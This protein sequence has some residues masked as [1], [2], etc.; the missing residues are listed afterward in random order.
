MLAALIIVFREVFEAGLIIGIVLAVTRQVQHRNRWIVGGVLAGVAGACLVAAFAGA[1]SQLFEGMGQELFNAAILGVAVV[2][3]T[4]HNVW[5]AKHGKE[6]AGEL[7]AVG[8]AVAQGSKSLLALAVVVGVAVLREG[9][10]VA[11]FLYG[12]AASDGGSAMSL[13]LGGLLGL[14]LGGA[15]CLFTYLGLLRIPPRALFNTTTALITL[16]AAGM[17][18]QAVA[19]LERANWL[20]ALD[21]VVWDT[22]WLLSENSILGRTLHTLIGYTDQP[23]QMQLVIY[24]VVIVVTVALMRMIAAERPRQAVATN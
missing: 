2:M 12:I 17:A 18:A 8:Q 19:F 4:W 24:L 15:V 13:F 6:M 5:M 20:T 10:E 22:G 7:R 3:L 21:A 23:T 16:L 9:S 14:V 11:L 1:L